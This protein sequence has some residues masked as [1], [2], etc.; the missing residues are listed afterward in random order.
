[1]SIISEADP[2]AG[3]L[4]CLQR[5]DLPAAELAAQEAVS[6]HPQLSRAWHLQGIVHAQHARLEPAVE[7]FRQAA[8]LEP[9]RALYSYNLGLALKEL[10]R[11]AEAVEAYR[12]AI[13]LKP[14]YLEARNNLANLLMQ[15]GEN[16]AALAEFRQLL[17]FFPESADSHCNL[18]NLLQD[19]GNFAEAITHYQRAVQLA[20]DHSAARENLGR[21]YTDEGLT[22]EANQVWQDWLK[23]EPDNPIAKH[24]V[25]SSTGSHALQRCHD[26]YVR[27]TFNEVFAKS[28]DSQ[29]ARIGYQAP[30]LVQQLIA[31]LRP[32]LIQARPA[33]A[34]VLDAGCGTGLCGP[35]IRNWAQ[36]LVGIDL[37]AD[38]LAEARRRAVYD[39]LIEAEITRFLS[40]Q[41]AAYDLIVCADTFCYFGKLDEAFTAA[42]QSLRPDGWLVFTVE[43]A[44][45]RIES[46]A[47]S[48]AEPDV[49]QK[50]SQATSPAGYQLR[51]HGRF[52]HT[53]DYV[54]QTLEQ[55]GLQIRAL[56]TAI[57]RKERGRDVEGLVVAACVPASI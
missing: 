55:A 7:C 14:K 5:G 56:Q 24:M 49:A 44:P 34:V 19:T 53:E 21:A 10:G 32:D 16:E 50:S 29:L 27:E 26:A 1:M 35:L 18:A 2:L 4:D 38:M 6:Q 51:Q 13:T 48:S 31:E 20:P 3:L 23:H 28:F 47:T 9:A 46:T 12:S 36:R 41:S 25:A 40:E 22:D 37:S 39:E 11:V 52:C 15:Q 8:T 43:K 42:V 54:R 30:Q 45:M 17:E 33:T 57:L